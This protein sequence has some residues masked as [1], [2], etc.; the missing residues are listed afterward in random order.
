[1]R[2]ATKTPKKVSPLRYAPGQSV[3]FQP[4]EHYEQMLIDRVN[5]PGFIWK[6]SLAERTALD[7]YVR[8]KAKA[9]AQT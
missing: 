4:N 1:M 3:A 2:H 9:Q 5:D 8:A 6:H 7:Y